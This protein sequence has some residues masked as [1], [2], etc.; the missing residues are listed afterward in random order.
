MYQRIRACTDDIELEVY[1]QS[2]DRT[3]R[4]EYLLKQ[5]G[6]EQQE[7]LEKIK[8]SLSMEDEEERRGS[9]RYV[10]VKGAPGSGK[11]A[12]LPEAALRAVRAGLTVL[13]VCP[14]GALVIFMVSRG[15]HLV[16]FGA[17]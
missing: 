9:D 7:V 16:A 14:T 17:S 10:Y 15:L 13:I 2:W 8:V 5:W 3:N 12:V 1:R 6:L 11:S 4:P